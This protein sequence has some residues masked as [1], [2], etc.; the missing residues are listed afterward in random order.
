[1]LNVND[2]EP[3]GGIGF[4]HMLEDGLEIVQGLATLPAERRRYV[5]RDLANL[6]DEAHRGSDVF[7]RDE[8]FSIRSNQLPYVALPLSSG[9]YPAMNDQHYQWILLL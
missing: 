5:L 9:T 6:Y 2:L 1:M 3:L 8:Y 4:R 7:E